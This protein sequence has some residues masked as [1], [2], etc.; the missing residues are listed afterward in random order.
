MKSEKGTNDVIFRNAIS[1]ENQ[2]KYVNQF[3]SD[4]LLN[5]KTRAMMMF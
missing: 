1:E 3:H 4:G 5:T 2:N